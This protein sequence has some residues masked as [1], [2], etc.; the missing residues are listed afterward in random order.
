MRKLFLTALVLGA[1]LSA[2]GQDP[3]PFRRSLS[4][5]AATGLAPCHM[6]IV[7]M[8]PSYERRRELAQNG[9]DADMDHAYYPAADLSL[10]WRTKEHWEHAFTTG[11]SWC[12]HRLI[13]YEAFGIDPNGKPRYDLQTGK[14]AG[15]ADSTPFFSLTWQARYLYNPHAGVQLYSAVGLGLITDWEGVLPLPAITF[16]AARYTTEHFYFFFEVPLNEVALFAHGGL[17]WRF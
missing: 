5:E 12:H 8:S 3:A 10:V 13:Q 9:Q 6:R 4:V 11:V 17:G 2:R 1:V 16:I 14:P 7:Y 15:W